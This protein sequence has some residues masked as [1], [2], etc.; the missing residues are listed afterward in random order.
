M[1]AAECPCSDS[2]TAAAVGS[3]EHTVPLGGLATTAAVYWNKWVISMG[4]AGIFVLW[5]LRTATFLPDEM[6]HNCIT[7][8]ENYP[9]GFLPQ[10]R[11]PLTAAQTVLKA[12]ICDAPMVTV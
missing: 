10:M 6:N 12:A 8:Y 9:V 4:V 11:S 2:V 7:I 5:G 3:R 1:S